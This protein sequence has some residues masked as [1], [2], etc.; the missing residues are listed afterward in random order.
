MPDTVIMV[1]TFVIMYS[2]KSISTLS[3]LICSSQMTLVEDRMKITTP[4]LW[5]E[6]WKVKE[7]ERPA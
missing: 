7:I 1:Q 3:Y 4:I 5:G 2:L 6:K